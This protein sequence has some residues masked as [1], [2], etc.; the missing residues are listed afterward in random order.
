MQLLLKTY[1]NYYYKLVI[2]CIGEIYFVTPLCF[3][4]TLQI[5]FLFANY[6]K[7]LDDDT[8][9]NRSYNVNCYDHLRIKWVVNI[10]TCYF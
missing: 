2:I 3:Q 9:I 5:R 8:I 10:K 1:K 6:S 4:F 7:S